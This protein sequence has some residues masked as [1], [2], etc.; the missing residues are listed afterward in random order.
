M[1]VTHEHQSWLLLVLIW[2]CD[3]SGP[4]IAA[5]R[6]MRYLRAN[7]LRHLISIFLVLS[8]YGARA[9]VEFGRTCR[10][11]I[12]P[13]TPLTSLFTRPFGA[14]KE[15]LDAVRSR[16]GPVYSSDRFDVRI[17]SAS[18]W[19][20]VFSP[21][22]LKEEI[23]TGVNELM[24]RY[25]AL[26]FHS[27]A[28]LH[29]LAEAHPGAAGELILKGGRSQWRDSTESSAFLTNAR[30]TWIGVPCF[31]GGRKHFSDI[32]KPERNGFGR[33]PDVLVLPVFSQRY[34]T[35]QDS[36]TVAHEL[37]HWVENRHSH[38]SLIWREGR[39]DFLS[40]VMTNQTEVVVPE[41]LDMELAHPDGSIYTKKLTLIRS[42]S[43]PTIASTSQIM[44]NLDLYHY[45]SQIISSFLYELAQQIG[46]KAAVDLVLWMD[47]LEGGMSI[48]NL[49]PLQELTFQHALE[50]MAGLPLSS[51][52]D[53]IYVDQ[54]DISQVRAAIN[55][56]LTAIGDLFRQWVQLGDL[57]SEDKVK[58]FQ[59]LDKKEI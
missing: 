3:L 32:L 12:L 55:D 5:L 52:T 31:L 51:G 26:G 6:Y 24:D 23:V 40:Y 33:F 27:R 34:H 45:N 53:A 9:E 25:D 13:Q 50:A 14:I 37:A 43:K 58:V 57:Q 46:M 7:N 29:V 1:S 10:G 56:Q 41:E 39:A 54:D 47:S 49:A 18:I 48:P 28:F 16:I 30:T 8:I 35:Y 2:G 21:A 20:N 15:N 22:K 36:R 17:L 38:R 4:S 19:R 59:L 11:L 42:L 44:P